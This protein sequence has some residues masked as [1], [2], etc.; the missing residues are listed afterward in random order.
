MTVAAIALREAVE[1]ATPR[2]LAID[3]A[4]S[5]RRPG[6]GA[7]S[8]L[9][10]IGH[11]VDS[12]ANNH[13]R[14]VRG[15]IEDHLDFAGYAQEEWVAVQRYRDQDWKDL[16]ELW[17]LYNL[18]I[19]NVMD[20]APEAVRMRPIERH[21]LDRIAFVALPVNEPATLDYLMSDYVHHLEHHLAQIFALPAVATGARPAS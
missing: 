10:I 16:V 6:D 4:A 1:S 20:A 7:W 5:A 9:E 15:Q 2:L 8:A 12:A 18:H 19:A 14:F 13:P 3:D 17:R 21:S 11:L